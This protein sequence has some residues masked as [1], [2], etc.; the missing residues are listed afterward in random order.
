MKFTIALTDLETLHKAAGLSKLKKTDVFTLF[1]CAGRVFTEFKGDVAGIEELV[2]ED[3]AVTVP[4]KNFV[5][6]I[7]TYKGTRLLNIEA[8]PDRLKVQNF[9]MPILG[10]NPSPTPPAQFRVFPAVDVG[11]GP[12][13]ATRS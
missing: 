1:A 5:D 8:G 13:G 6:L 12:Q 9:S 10:Y 7:K 4:A 3:G 11:P 2:L